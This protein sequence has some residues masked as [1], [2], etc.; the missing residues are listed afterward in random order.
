M[1]RPDKGLP[2]PARRVLGERNGAAVLTED[3]VIWIRAASESCR[4]LAKQFK[5][6]H[7]TI[8]AIK[9]GDSWAWLK[10]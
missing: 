10:E 1:A 8:S 2:C 3:A 7:A 9:R 6:A 4:Y 5:V